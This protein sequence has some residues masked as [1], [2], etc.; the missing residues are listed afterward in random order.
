MIN[1]QIIE[2]LQILLHK[3]DTTLLEKL[4]FKENTFSEPLLIA[5][6]NNKK[7][8]KNNELWKII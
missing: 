8:V 7:L 3:E 5:Y 2:N 6:F 4:S 1:T